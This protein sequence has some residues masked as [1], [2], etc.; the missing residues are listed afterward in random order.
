MSRAIFGFVFLAVVLAAC[1]SP[2]PT[3]IPSP[4]ITIEETWGRPSP[5]VAQAG[6]FYM[7]IRNTGAV[8]DKLIAG[9]ST[10]CGT[11][12]LHE[13]YQMA[14]GM[15]GMRLVTGGSIEVPA[16]GKAELK[17]GGLHIMCIEKKVDF[18]S[19]VKIPLTLVFEKSGEMQV[20]VE[21]RDTGM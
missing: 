15:M 7:T 13:S 6:A 2:T 4:K 11:V 10:G 21:I 1:A 19:G 16:N 18:K 9:K 5:K 3:A 12:E 17:V 14:D 20:E 8:A